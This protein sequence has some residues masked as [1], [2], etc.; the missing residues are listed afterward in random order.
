MDGLS[1]IGLALMVVPDKLMPT[2]LRGID[3]ESNHLSMKLPNR[4]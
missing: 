2:R 3:Q 1:V 4:G